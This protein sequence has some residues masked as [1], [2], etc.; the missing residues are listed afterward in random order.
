MAGV[1]FSREP[2]RARV[3]C[4]SVAEQP[5]GSVL[6]VACRL[7]GLLIAC[8]LLDRHL[9]ADESED[10][11]GQERDDQQ[12]AS[13]KNPASRSVGLILYTCH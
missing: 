5:C 12:Q 8:G 13:P 10:A 4:K 7:L 3:C 11:E 1:L 2:L 6:L 9:G